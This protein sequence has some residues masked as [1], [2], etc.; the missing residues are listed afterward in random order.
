MQINKK[1]I[2]ATIWYVLI[3]LIAI[4]LIIG[5]VVAFSYSGIISDTL[6]HDQSKIEQL[7]SDE[8]IDSQYYSSD[9]DSDEALQ[10]KGLEVCE[11][12]ESEGMTLL[13][14]DGTLP[15]GK[16]KKVSLFGMTST[17]P[18]FGGTGSGSIDTKIAVRPKEAFEN[19][20][21]TVNPILDEFNS[22]KD[23][24]YKRT[25][26]AIEGNA[27]V[28]YT[29]NE[30]P[31]NEYTSD[32]LNSFSTYNDAAIVFIGRS[33]GEGSDL[34]QTNTEN[35]DKGYLAISQNEK[36]MLKLVQDNFE[37]IIVII[38]SSNSMELGWLKDYSHIKA[39]LWVGS[40]GTT[41]FNAVAKA[42]TG[43]Y[44]PSGRLVDT[45]ASDSHSAPASVNFGDFSYTNSNDLNDLNEPYFMSTQYTGKNYVVY[46]E[47]IYIGYR[48]YE[49]RYEDT[50]LNQGDASSNV[51][52]YSST[53][54]WNYS[55]EV[56][57]PFGYG[58]SYTTF[59]YSDYNVEN[60]G[61]NYEVSV[62]VKNTGDTKGKEIVQVYM[63]SPYTDYDKKYKIEKS[64]IELVGFEK[65]KDLEPNESQKITITIDENKLRT[66][67]A[68]NSKTYIQDGGTYLCFLH[69]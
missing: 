13:E 15:L 32:V 31:V 9:Y 26:A 65:T 24:D 69:L 19:V 53:N 6:G 54:N 30:C 28:D 42:F 68:Y 63:Q 37:T 7:P 59:S 16:N 48:Y 52:T 23:D 34:S 5:N 62:T 61:S 3:A 33:G 45:Y 11:E 8:V 60:K 25:S 36:D 4:A 66:Y 58:L 49:T 67:D 1:V 17:N 40:V 18:V 55:Q 50:V 64:S 43:E 41:G 44:N 22:K 10:K 56:T 20:G 29:V 2:K 51:G 57:Y 14:N 27:G 39:A 47:G 12:V 35:G 38:N 21:Y 46:Q